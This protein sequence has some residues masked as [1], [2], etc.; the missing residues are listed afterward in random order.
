MQPRAAVGA[1]RAQLHE[2]LR[3]LVGSA[4]R[5][6]LIDFPNTANVGDSAIYLGELACLSALKVP[7]PRFICDLRT[8]DR[9]ELVRALGPSG[10]ILF[11][12]GGSLGDVWPA[13]QELRE[14]IIRA[15]PDHAIVQFPQ[16][17]HFERVDALRRARAS[18]NA[19]RR[20]TLLVR[21]R[22]SLEVAQSEFTAATILCPDAAL[23][24]GP[25]D[26][27]VRPTHRRVWL[28]RTDKES[29]VPVPAGAEP[30]VDWLDEPPMW[31]R[32][33]SY[34]L[35]GA[36]RRRPFRPIARP[37]LMR[38]YA[39][40]ARE[41]LRRGLGL[42]ASGEVVI[43]DRLHA[44]I[45]CLLMGIPH[46][47]LDNS[48][49]KLSSFFQTWTRDVDNVRWANSPEEAARVAA[50]LHEAE[51]DEMHPGG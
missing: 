34:R 14:E 40:L 26:R 39:S 49:G 43:T 29:R 22:R 9:A 24:L 16:T 21:D 3:P 45:L 46:V 32:S 48:Y 18:L 11:A 47:V 36:V 15:F 5:V 20:M 12:G 8:Y 33:L 2:T 38:L 37:L 27:P 6:A 31:R 41:R 17:I 4:E 7:F 19:H 44:H 30:V 23:S 10:L 35:M 50:E 28:M 13:A 42:L 1:L 25:L 51:H